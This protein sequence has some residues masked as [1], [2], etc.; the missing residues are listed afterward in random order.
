MVDV[1]LE[2]VNDKSISDRAKFIH[3]LLLAM[4]DDNPD[5][6]RLPALS[7][8][9][10]GTIYKYLKELEVAG[11]IERKKI[12]DNGKIAYTEYIIRYEK[13]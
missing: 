12:R 3:I 5:I 1:P 2:L 9:N 11:W 10:M 6:N 13:A 8:L 7:G 4:Q